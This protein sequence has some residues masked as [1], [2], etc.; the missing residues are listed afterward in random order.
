MSFRI[1][2]APL[3]YPD[4]LHQVPL[5]ARPAKLQHDRLDFALGNY[6]PSCWVMGTAFRSLRLSRMTIE[7][8]MCGP[9]LR[10]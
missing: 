2:S 5:E 1:V 3:W 9:T 8:S 6:L 7:S 4:K 10:S